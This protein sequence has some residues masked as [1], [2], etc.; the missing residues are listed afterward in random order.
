MKKKIILLVN[1]FI[2]IMLQAQVSKTVNVSSAG[3]LHE[4]HS[5]EELNTV[6]DLTITGTLDAR[7]FKTMRDEMPV[8]A[9]ID[10]SGVVAI[11]AYS[12]TEGTDADYRD[13][14]ANQIPI[15]AFY[16][17]TGNIPKLTLTTFVFPPSV[18]SM[19]NYAFN[20]CA[21][22]A[23]TLNLP[24]LL[25][26]IGSSAFGNCTGL[27]GT[28][29]LPKNVTTIGSY[30]FKGCSGFSS[31]SIPSSVTSIQSW[32]FGDCTGLNSI[33]VAWFTPLNFGT[34]NDVFT[35][36]NK[37]TC[38]L[39]VPSGTAAL[40]D[41]ASQWTDFV[42][43]VEIPGIIISADALTL[44]ANYGSSK[45]VGIS[46]ST[47]W[48]ASS[49]QEWLTLSSGNGT[50]GISTLNLT[51][52]ANLT[53]TSRTATIAITATGFS[54]KTITI[55]QNSG[56][57][58]G[59]LYALLGESIAT[60]TSLA[61]TGSIDA[62]DFKTMRD[63]MPLLATV[64][65]S[66]VTIVYYSGTEG[67]KE[68]VLEYNGN[69]IPNNAFCN[70]DT[71]AGKTSLES[72]TFPASLYSINSE[73]F[74]NCTGLTGTLT[75]PSSV[76]EIGIYAFAGCTGLTGT[77]TIPSNL[78]DIE[79]YAFEGCVGFTETLDLS[80]SSFVESI[81]TG[82]F[83]GCSSL[84][85]III[86]STVYE[87][88]D[89]AFA[90]CSGL[91]S[92][93]VARRTPVDLSGSTNVFSG[94]DVSSCILNV[95]YGTLAAY[96][97]ADQWT[98][99]VHI[100]ESTH[101]ETT[102]YGWGDP[103]WTVGEW[104]NGEPD[105]FTNV[106]IA[107]SCTVDGD[108]EVFNLTIETGNSI[109]ID[110]DYTLNVNGNLT[111]K[112][113]GTLIEYGTLNVTGTTKVEQYLTGKSGETTSDNWWYISSPVTGATS[114]IFNPASTALDKNMFG[115][116]NEEI[117]KYP[118]IK[119]NDVTLSVGKGYVLKIGGSSATY[120]FTGTLNNGDI[121]VTVTRTG[122]SADKR[123]FNLIGNPYPSFLNWNEI[124]QYGI[125]GG[126]R[127]DISPTIWYR[128]RNHEGEMIFDTF[129]GSTGS[130]NG[131]YGEVREFIPPM[132]AFWMKVVDDGTLGTPVQNEVSIT[133]NNNMRSALDSY[134]YSKELRV[135]SVDERQIVRIK[136]SNGVNTDG[137][138]IV[139]DPKAIDAFDY[140]DSQ[141]MSNANVNI[142]E[143]YT[144]AGNEELVINHLNNFS[145]DKK[146]SLG[147][148]PGKKGVF[149][150]EASQIT[151]LDSNLKVMLLD[152]Q[153]NSE[154]ELVVGI[155]YIFNSEAQ[156]TND[157]FSILF[158][159]TSMITDLSNTINNENILV[160]INP[161]KKI[162][163]VCNA[164]ITGLS[165][166]SVYNAMGQKLTQQNIESSITEINNMFTS[167]I[168][169]VSI[170]TGG[171][172]I[173]RKLIIK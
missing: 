59:G 17:I 143:I 108:Y 91:T 117:I 74:Y 85:S 154:Q 105:E 128:T 20:Q 15:L 13:Y 47:D 124:T 164:Q 158:K 119:T 160:Y 147:F 77:L 66:N 100:V 131:I 50:S 94:V 6:T 83:K 62:R 170:K 35:N 111:I 64:D 81:Y 172:S 8:L 75:I 127:T 96:A 52:I 159:S 3:G 4:A 162:N 38:I 30:A 68:D 33:N 93:D 54:N 89:E 57:T 97:A 104:S 12:G 14:P 69:A 41:A 112:N 101:G 151:N 18:T 148:R 45:S 78:W 115:F 84:S 70:P 82:A 149:S 103:Y 80:S 5:S 87:I 114:A 61:L 28:L 67:T 53:S 145:P 163:V 168:Y 25:E 116:Y 95:P 146:L 152:K 118:Q 29:T 122:T 99:F 9:V 65:L 73:A 90:G 60:T 110:Y 56:V 126:E 49:D 48:S 21:N 173:N 132:Q 138:I 142:P 40:Y 141:K 156:V 44:S 71:K 167:G 113:M 32:A 144:F 43:I 166:V 153:T 161:N 46:S 63:D 37:N 10:L 1:L 169:I 88:Y 79:A 136:V 86:P 7:D 130:D 2:I 42:N 121:P 92:I 98:D 155:P 36:V 19:S 102:F 76:E 26:T 150:I 27:T 157:R 135:R 139:A 123:G 125:E 39:N 22:L 23:G 120:T 11:A 134:E 24:P 133:F 51:A 129:D 171:Q 165:S 107:G 16:R 137:T 34:N 72:I 140:Y 109:L 58:P 31:V 106:I 55:T